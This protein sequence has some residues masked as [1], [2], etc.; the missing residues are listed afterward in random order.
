[1][2]WIA[3]KRAPILPGNDVDS[4][5]MSAAH[6]LERFSVRTGLDVGSCS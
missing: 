1:M 3:G 2:R 6:L 4:G 5:S